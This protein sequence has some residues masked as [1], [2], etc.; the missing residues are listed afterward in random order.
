MAGGFTLL[1]LELQVQVNG[2]TVN[3]FETRPYEITSTISKTDAVSSVGWVEP[4]RVVSSDTFGDIQSFYNKTII[5]PRRNPP[6][7]IVLSF[8]L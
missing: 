2:F 6:K 7:S 5:N 1:A 8:E 3:G 4:I